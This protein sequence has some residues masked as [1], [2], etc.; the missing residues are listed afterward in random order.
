M[1]RY[2]ATAVILLCYAVLLSAFGISLAWIS[3]TRDVVPPLSF[4][5]GGPEEYA[6]Y[7]IRSEDGVTAVGTAVGTV[8]RE[9]V[10]ASPS[11]LAEDLELGKISNLSTLEYS[12]YVYYVVRVPKE[13][14]GSVTLSVGYGDT[15]EDGNHFKL[16]VPIKDGE[17]NVST[18]EDGS[19]HT[20]LLT[21]AATLDAIRAVE[22]DKGDTFLA[23]SLALSDLAPEGEHA[24]ADIEALF[25]DAPTY[26]LNSAPPVAT[27]DTAAEDGD[28]YYVY[29]RL[30]PNLSLYKHFI[31]HLWNR[32]PFFL[33][34]EVRVTLDVSAQDLAP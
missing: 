32:M 18:G 28:Y 14:G 19:I 13:Q 7:R 29:L 2:K 22:T 6:L 24:L 25:A 23:Y 3:N 4:S 15:D 27:Y 11:F 21:D 30:Q 9:S 33:A 16:Y 8:G 10:D 1:K 31:E 26:A 17:G 34:Y 20:E 5:A 12:N